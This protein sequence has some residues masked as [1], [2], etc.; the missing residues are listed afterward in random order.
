MNSREKILKALE[1]SNTAPGR[2]PEL[3]TDPIGFENPIDTFTLS[4]EAAGGEA[5]EPKGDLMQAILEAFEETDRLVDTRTSQIRLPEDPEETDLLILEARFGVA[6]NGAIWIDPGRRYPRA[7]LTLAKN[8][9]IVLPKASIVPTMHE[10]YAHIDLS[11]IDY[12]LFLSGPSKT[13]DIE[14]ALVI[15][16]HGAIGMKV[17]LV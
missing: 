5:R 13:A 7:L 2:V 16:A 9:A 1:N 12:A 17:F 11:E 14:Q 3:E 10:A 4:L 8:L 6:E 15:G